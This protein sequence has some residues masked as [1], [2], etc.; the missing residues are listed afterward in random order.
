MNNYEG[1]FLLDHGKVKNEVQ[2]GIDEITALIGKQGGEIEKIGKWDERKLA[3]E[4]RRQKRGVYVLAHFRFSGD[5][6]DE[7]RRDFQLN[8]L[9]VRQ[10]FVRLPAKF[11][12][13][14]TASE[15]DQ[16]FGTRDFRDR[17]PRRDGPGGRPD[18]SSDRPAPKPADAAPKTEE[19]P[20]P[21]GA[22]SPE[23]TES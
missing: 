10:L 2:K 17:G 19:A 16:A 23:K 6:I 12:P 4:I 15:L 22:A 11:P 21:A 3:Y 20:A 13:F 8:E 7:L 1:L 14:M 18:R 5:K 9:V